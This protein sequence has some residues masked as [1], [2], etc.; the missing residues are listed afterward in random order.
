MEIPKQGSL[1]VHFQIEPTPKLVKEMVAL[2]YQ[3]LHS[4]PIWRL[5]RY[6]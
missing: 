1:M 2:L 5:L 3:K 6:R 4:D